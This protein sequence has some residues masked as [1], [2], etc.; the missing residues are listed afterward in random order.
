MKI[1][2][3]ILGHSSI[4]QTMD[5]CSHVAEDMKGDAA[6]RATRGMSGTTPSTGPSSA[7]WKV[8]SSPKYLKLDF[9]HSSRIAKRFG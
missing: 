2:Q 9:F 5:T 8:T 4:M 6:D 3:S 7:S 1:V